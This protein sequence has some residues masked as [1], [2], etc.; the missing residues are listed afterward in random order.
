MEHKASLRKL[1]ACLFVGLFSEIAS[2]PGP[3]G[4]GIFIP[5]DNF[6]QKKWNTGMIILKYYAHSF[7]AVS[8]VDFWITFYHRP[9][10]KQIHIRLLIWF[11]DTALIGTPLSALAYI[12]LTALLTTFQCSKSTRKTQEKFSKPRYSKNFLQKKKK[13]KLL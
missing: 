4:N 11:S 12:L 1:M 13:N 3:E 6:L 10:K 5:K 8:P 9:K 7:Y 2:L